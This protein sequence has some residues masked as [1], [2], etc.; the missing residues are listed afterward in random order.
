MCVSCSGRCGGGKKDRSLGNVVKLIVAAPVAG[1]SAS[2]IY[3]CSQLS[4]RVSVWPAS[5]YRDACISG[6]FHIPHHRCTGT[7]KIAHVHCV[8]S[9]SD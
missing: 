8:R 4:L 3:E 7:G 1:M 5:F 6:C 9:F 2:R